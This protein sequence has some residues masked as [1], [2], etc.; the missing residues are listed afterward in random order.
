MINLLL[1]GNGCRQ[2]GMN[3]VCTPLMKQ[4]TYF[5]A[6]TPRDV[7]DL[8]TVEIVSDFDHTF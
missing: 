1:H 3:S 8:I 6:S 4:K 5:P 2:S 7:L